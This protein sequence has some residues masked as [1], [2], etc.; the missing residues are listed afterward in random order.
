MDWQY[1]NG[2]LGNTE[3]LSIGDC[4]RLTATPEDSND[5]W[6]LTETIFVD[7]GSEPEG[8]FIQIGA[9]VSTGTASSTLPFPTACI[10]V[11]ARYW[12]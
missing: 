10:P 3:F 12:C 11:C 7:V 2:N 8:T 9:N 1:R 6:D 5:V 4:S